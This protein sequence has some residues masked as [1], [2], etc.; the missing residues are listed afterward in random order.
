MMLLGCSGMLLTVCTCCP[1][2]LLLDSIRRACP[3]FQ[4][5][6]AAPCKAPTDL[7]PPPHLC[8]VA[9]CRGYP[10]DGAPRRPA[11]VCGQAA[12]LPH[13]H[14]GEPQKVQVEDGAALKGACCCCCSSGVLRGSLEG[15]PNAATLRELS[16]G[17]LGREVLLCSTDVSHCSA[18]V[19]PPLPPSPARQDEIHELLLQFAGQG[20]TVLR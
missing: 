19:S 13:T 3:L 12:Q 7:A 9:F 20:A 18:D 11:G 14:A 17:K 8:F 1:L 15:V 6:A 4:P 5:A 16:C 10:A 2:P